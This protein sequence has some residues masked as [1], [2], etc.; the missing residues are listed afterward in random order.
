MSD[1]ADN[2]DQTI[3]LELSARLAAVRRNTGPQLAPI[4]MCHNCEADLEPGKLFCAALG[5]GLSECQEDY[6][7]RVRRAA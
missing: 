5:D 3:Q 2:A 6:E 1:I 7:K 4:C